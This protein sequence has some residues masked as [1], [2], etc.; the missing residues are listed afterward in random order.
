MKVKAVGEIGKAIVESDQFPAGQCTQPLFTIG[1]EFLQFLQQKLQIG[2]ECIRIFGIFSAQTVANV[3]GHDSGVPGG[4]P[5]VRIVFV[6]MIIAV[7]V[8]V[9]VVFSV[10]HDIDTGG[11]VDDG[12][13]TGEDI[14][15][16]FFQPLFKFRH[17]RQL[18]LV[19]IPW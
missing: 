17:L 14:I 13:N 16:K 19:E 2:S 18:Q 9:T 15:H 3:P 10:G 5:D 4:E 8:C 7:L 12:F 11:T 1:P 6:M